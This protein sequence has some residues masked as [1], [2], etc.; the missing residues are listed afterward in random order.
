MFINKM[1]I[2]D[3]ENKN[4]ECVAMQKSISDIK[5]YVTDFSVIKHSKVNDNN[6]KT[7]EDR[8]KKTKEDKENYLTCM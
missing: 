7:D 1:D 8:L 5:K 6:I 4:F 2:V 3:H